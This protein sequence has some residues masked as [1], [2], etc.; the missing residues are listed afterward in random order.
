M[1]DRQAER[2]DV[3]KSGEE[4]AL[5]GRFRDCLFGSADADAIEQ[6]AR[7]DE[8]HA[9][10]TLYCIRYSLGLPSHSLV[11]YFLSSA[12]FASASLFFLRSIFFSLPHLQELEAISVFFSLLALLLIL[13][14]LC[15]C[16]LPLT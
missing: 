6:R 16:L 15:V 11:S 1:R 2:E 3:E 12:A 14:L 9:D 4:V 13:R 8:Q 5:G 10:I 7:E